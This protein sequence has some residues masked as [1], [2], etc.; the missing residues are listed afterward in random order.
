MTT[1]DYI[2]DRLIAMGF[3][4]KLVTYVWGEKVEADKDE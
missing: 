4:E 2:I 3:D 1:N